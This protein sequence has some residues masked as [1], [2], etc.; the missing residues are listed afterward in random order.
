MSNDDGGVLRPGGRLSG[1][2]VAVFCY[3]LG[4]RA[5]DVRRMCRSIF[6]DDGIIGIEQGKTGKRL[7]LP[8][9]D[10]LQSYV[11]RVPAGREELVINENTGGPT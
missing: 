4:Q 6:E 8:I 3:E 10:V 2:P 11:V 9:S 1:A 7:V 5:G